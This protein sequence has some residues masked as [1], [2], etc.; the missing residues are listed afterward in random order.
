MVLWILIKLA[1]SLFLF[2]ILLYKINVWISEV[3]QVFLT[4]SFT[5]AGFNIT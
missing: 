2:K 4:S 5:F 1:E 3:L